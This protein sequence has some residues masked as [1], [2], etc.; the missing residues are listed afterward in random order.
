MSRN[1][2]VF[3]I[4]VTK[5]NEPV[6]PAN[7]KLDELKPGQIGIFDANTNLSSVGASP[8]KE[9]YLAVGVDRDGDGVS[10]SINT[11][12]GQIIQ[13]EN[14]RFTSNK[15]YVAPKPMV[16]EITDLKPTCNSDYSIKL[17]FRNIEIYKK[18]GYNQYTHTYSVK[19][20]PCDDCEDCS[21]EDCNE[22]VKLLV[23]AVNADTHGLVKAEAINGGAVV[24][25]IDA[26]IATNKAVNEDDDKTNDV[27]LSIRLTSIPTAISKFYSINTRYYH[28]R[29]TVIIP[30]L[31]D[32]FRYSGEVTITQEATFEEGS[33]YDIKQKEYHAGS[34]NGKPGPY[35]TYSVTGLAREG[36]EYFADQNVNYDQLSITYD[37]ASSSGWLEYLNNLATEIAIPSTDTI[38]KSTL[39]KALNDLGVSI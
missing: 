31:V 8:L 14:I 9:F 21:S 24:T 13:F 2:D 34:W 30:S 27:C 17:E 37:Q 28:P 25:D 22:L 20:A 6:L 1:N 29:Q 35:K 18:Q 7:K 5:G 39:V 38:T 15:P 16:A 4:L 23:K 33:G 19:T 12:A 10:E 36:F 26:F 32:D 11:S 3:Q